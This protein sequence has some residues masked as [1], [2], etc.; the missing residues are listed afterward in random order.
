V[1]FASLSELLAEIILTGS[2][3][4]CLSQITLTYTEDGPRTPSL[5]NGVINTNSFVPGDIA[6]GAS[7]SLNDNLISPKSNFGS[8]LMRSIPLKRE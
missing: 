5:S 7:R 2:L 8:P 1:Q 3:D 6:T 4:F